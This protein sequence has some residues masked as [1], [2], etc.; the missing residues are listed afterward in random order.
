MTTLTKGRSRDSVRN[1]FCWPA[2]PTN[3][4]QRNSKSENILKR[5]FS[6]KLAFSFKTTGISTQLLSNAVHDVYQH[7]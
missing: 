6:D 5:Y 4:L 3:E 2:A 1:Q 7:S